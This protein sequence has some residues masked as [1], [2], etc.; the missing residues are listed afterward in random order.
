MFI[1]NERLM[2]YLIPFS[3]ELIKWNLLLANNKTFNQ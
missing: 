1:L 2:G 3:G